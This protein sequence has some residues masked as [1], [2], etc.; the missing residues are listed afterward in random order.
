MSPLTR[1][2]IG[3]FLFAAIM[4]GGFVFW[5]TVYFNVP[6]SKAHWWL[7]GFLWFMAFGACWRA[8]IE[9]EALQFMG[10]N[11]ERE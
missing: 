7:F 10:R 5:M 6:W 4:A 9:I 2:Q 11:I 1:V 3:S 8:L